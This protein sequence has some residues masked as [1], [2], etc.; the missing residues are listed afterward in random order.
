MCIFFIRYLLKFWKK[1]GF[2]IVEG[3]YI[4]YTDIYIVY[5]IRVNVP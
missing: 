5:N 2:K 4:K 1:L 3:R